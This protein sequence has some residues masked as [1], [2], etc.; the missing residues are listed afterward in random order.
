MWIIEGNLSYEII[1]VNLHEHNGKHEVW[2][3][4][5]DGKTKLVKKGSK[6][7]VTEI[8]EAI[9]FSIKKGEKVLEL[10]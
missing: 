4:K 8:K 7:E 1:G 9:D 2:V 10:V 6:E 3:T 5:K